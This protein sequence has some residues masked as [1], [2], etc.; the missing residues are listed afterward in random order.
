MNLSR[1]ALKLSTAALTFAAVGGGALASTASAQTNPPLQAQ[2]ASPAKVMQLVNVKS[3]EQQLA[4]SQLAL[5][6]VVS[7]GN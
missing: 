7:P 3:L 5:V 4:Q 6:S 1:K 2:V